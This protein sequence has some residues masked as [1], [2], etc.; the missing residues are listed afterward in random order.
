MDIAGC[1]ALTVRLSS[2]LVNG[3]IPKLQPLVINHVQV[4]RNSQ[5]CGHEIIVHYKAQN[6]IL[7][8]K[9][10]MSLVNCGPTTDSIRPVISN[11]M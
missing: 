5:G 6:K 1:G 4:L 7:P 11:P 8:I 3:T 9:N 10:P 2:A